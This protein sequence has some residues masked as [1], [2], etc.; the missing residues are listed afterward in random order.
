MTTLNKILQ[1]FIGIIIFGL[2]ILLFREFASEYLRPY[3]QEQI[4]LAHGLIL[5]ISNFILRH[6]IPHVLIVPLGLIGIG[7]SLSGLNRY[8]RML[9]PYSKYVTIISLI[10]LLSFGGSRL[11]TNIKKTEDACCPKKEDKI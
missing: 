6:I 10:V 5:L 2:Y 4:M 11:Q 3:N 7:S 1:V 9:G 8:W